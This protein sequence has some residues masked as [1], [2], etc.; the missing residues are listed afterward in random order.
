[1]VIIFW[2]SLGL[3]FYTLFG[4][5]IIL[6]LLAKLKDKSVEEYNCEKVNWPKVTLVIAAY[7][8]EK[9]IGHK[10]E[11][12]LKLNY[13][14][15]QL[16]IIV[17][18]DNSSD[19][20]DNIVRSYA[21]EGIELHR[22]PKRGGKLAGHKSVLK[23][24]KSE[25]VI[26]S[27]ATTIY[28]SD[29][30]KE[31]VKHF[32]RKDAGCVGGVLTYKDHNI[33]ESAL[34]EQGYFSYEVFIR[35]MENQVDSVPVVSGA[36]YAIRKELYGDIPHHL[37]DDLI[38]PLYVK[39]LGYKTLFEPNAKCW[40]TTARDLKEEFLKRKRIAAQ[41]VSGLFCMRGLLNPFKYPLFSWILFSHKALRLILPFLY[42]LI[43]ISG[44]ALLI[45]RF[46]LAPIAVAL[47][48]IFCAYLFGR[49]MGIFHNVKRH[50]SFPMYFIVFHM[51]IILGI[52]ESLFG[53]KYA[54]W[55]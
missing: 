40:E 47:G 49:Y 15:A 18:S 12:S 10:I 54:T 7:N 45:G 37:A 50:I 35:K 1:M 53:K 39:K 32:A 51:G 2:C 24:I 34:K 13:P 36:I 6:F 8:E 17:V 55:R 31:L 20:T 25:I 26:F 14:K 38:N 16:D 33:E 41:N 52:L 21:N 44:L 46:G 42:V 27:D 30:I 11:N 28:H 43:V 23:G 29:A 4:Y 3:I 22:M 19:E 9:V 48:I 5:P